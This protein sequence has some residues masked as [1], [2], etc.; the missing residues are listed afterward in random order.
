MEKDEIKELNRYLNEMFIYLEQCDALLLRQARYIGWLNAKYKKRVQDKIKDIELEENHLTYEEVYQLARNIINEIDPKYLT[1]YDQLIESGKLDFDYEQEIDDS[2]MRIIRNGNN[3]TKLIDVRREFNCNDVLSLIHE[4][5]HYT[6]RKK[7]FSNVRYYFTEFLSIYFELYAIDYLLKQNI[8][9]KELGLFDRLQNTYQ[10]SK[11]MNIYVVVLLAYEKFGEIDENTLPLLQQNFLQT[12]NESWKDIC[13]TTYKNLRKVE[14]DNQYILEN[15]PKRLG[16]LLGEN[17]YSSDYRY[18]LGTILA[19][20]ARKYSNLKDV[21]YLNDHINEC[22]DKSILKICL[23]I[24]IDLN[25]Q[26]FE[27]KALEAID[28]KI[29]EYSAYME[30]PKAFVKTKNEAQK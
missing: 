27:E 26:D 24:G 12:D 19:F 8:N 20:Y 13:H 5:F 15:D 11:R 23:S 28:E 3:T 30:K 7:E 9:G 29:E 6:N 10:L 14:K 1:E 4:F 17:Y 25:A 2:V 22:Q 21:V 18:L 16:Q